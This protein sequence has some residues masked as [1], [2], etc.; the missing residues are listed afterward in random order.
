M[1]NLFT[2]R[3]SCRERVLRKCAAMRAAKERNRLARSDSMRD[4]GGIATDGVLGAHSIRLL[5][6]PGDENR[7]A[8]VAD[9]KHREA[10]TLRGVTRCIAEMVWRKTGKDA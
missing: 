5:A 8:V 2:E 1:S 3:K 4:V 10:R 7:L 9:G 6:Y